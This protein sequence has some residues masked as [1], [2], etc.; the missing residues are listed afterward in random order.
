[1]RG[2]WS[3]YAELDEFLVLLRR[4]LVISAWLRD[5]YRPDIGTN[6]ATSL[7]EREYWFLEPS[8]SH[9]I[10]IKLRRGAVVRIYMLL[11]RG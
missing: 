6:P 5:G 9:L 3:P 8:M 4:I 2:R 1:L 7:T 11:Q 10:W